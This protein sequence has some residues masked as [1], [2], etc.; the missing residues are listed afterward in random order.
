[1]SI[2]KIMLIL[3]TILCGGVAVVIATIYA[4]SGSDVW[5]KALLAGVI[6]WIAVFPVMALHWIIDKVV[7][8]IVNQSTKQLTIDGGG[9]I[10]TNH[11]CPKCGKILD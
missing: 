5:W 11:P 10:E 4:I 8:K 2:Y 3:S 9:V 6:A 7:E 1:M